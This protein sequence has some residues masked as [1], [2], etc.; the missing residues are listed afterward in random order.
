MS[1]NTSSNKFRKVNIDDF[2]P[3]KFKDETVEGEEQGPN[4]AEVNTFLTQYPFTINI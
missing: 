3:E 4:E 2:D 1:K